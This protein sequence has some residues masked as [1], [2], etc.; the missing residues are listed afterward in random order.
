M[1]LTECVR[2]TEEFLCDRAIKPLDKTIAL[3][4]AR[5]DPAMFNVS[6][7]K[8]VPLL[9]EGQDVIVRRGRSTGLC[10]VVPEAWYQRYGRLNRAR[11]RSWS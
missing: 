8:D 5:H 6:E 7:G 9:E 10:S 1:K 2:Q 11:A 4:P 3:P